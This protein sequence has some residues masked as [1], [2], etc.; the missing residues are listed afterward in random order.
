VKDTILRT[1]VLSAMRESTLVMMEAGL[2]LLVH[3]VAFY[4]I[5]E[6]SQLPMTVHQI[7]QFARR[8][9]FQVSRVPAVCFVKAENTC[10]IMDLTPQITMLFLTV[11]FVPGESIVDM[12]LPRAYRVEVVDIWTI[13]EHQPY[14]MTVWRT[15]LFVLL[16]AGWVA[17]DPQHA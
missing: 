13:L 10:L 5:V 14:T 1:I 8:G 7:A 16:V 4:K 2:A 11:A 12:V 9:P 17:L 3:P 15:V 6:F